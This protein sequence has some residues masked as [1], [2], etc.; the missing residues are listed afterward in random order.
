[1]IAY[2]AVRKGNQIGVADTT[3][4][5]VQKPDVKELLQ[6][7]TEPHGEDFRVFWDLD[8][9]VGDMFSILP[10]N[11]QID[12]LERERTTIM[13][14]EPARY[15]IWYYQK[16]ILVVRKGGTKAIYY[17]LKQF[18][19]DET[20]EPPTLAELKDKAQAVIDECGS[21][22][23]NLTR[24]SSH[25]AVNDFI[26]DN[27]DLPTWRDYPDDVVHYYW[28]DAGIHWVEAHKLGWF[29]E[30]HDY[31][32]R[33]SYPASA[34][35]LLD[36][37]YGEWV[38]TGRHYDPKATY[39]IYRAGVNMNA[40]VHPIPYVNRSGDYFYPRG[41]WQVHLT[42]QEA[43]LIYEYKLGTIKIHDGWSWYPKSVVRPMQLSIFKLYRN[44]DKS[45]MLARLMKLGATSFYGRFLF[46]KPDGKYGANFNPIYGR[47]IEA[48]NNVKLARFV[49]ENKLVNDLIHVST[50]GL[51]T[52][53]KV[54][55]VDSGLVGSW[56]YEG[57]SPALAVSSSEV[58]YGDRRPCQFTYEEA[59]ELVKAD[60]TAVAWSKP[61]SRRLVL[62]DVVNG[63]SS[64]DNR[65][66][67]TK[68]FRMPL[69]NDRHFPQRPID[70][71]DLLRKEWQSRPIKVSKLSKPIIVESVEY[72][73]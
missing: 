13:T 65:V 11:N 39:G 1:M 64:P 59:M 68:G 32:I 36:T 70:G 72:E 55:V 62:A 24:L 60:P 35:E 30:T 73:E 12:L 7:L 53:R 2:K 21:V 41:Y 38:H 56:K 19:P 45:P 29:P 69:E 9:S 67:T 34:S 27:I 17:H 5:R 61:A 48:I 33:S 28:Q 8:T 52:T 31:D 58:F 44:R 26:F 43:D 10:K 20:P 6:Y 18:Y 15:T 47:M 57:G 40:Q 54:P 42:K 16:K 37:R 46:V 22:G 49:L 23:I 63:V 50:D 14:D 51:L 4:D 71:A 66:K 3:G 25:T